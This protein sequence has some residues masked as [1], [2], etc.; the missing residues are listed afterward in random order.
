MQSRI[1]AGAR[2]TVCIKHH[3]ICVQ[4][5]KKSS[6][7]KIVTAFLRCEFVVDR[8]EF[9]PVT[10]RLKGT[11]K[12]NFLLIILQRLSRRVI[13]VNKGQ[14]SVVAVLHGTIVHARLDG[15]LI[16]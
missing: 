8:A 5:A 16:M 1:F 10:N 7:E 6:N 11:A 9:K 14:S 2:P 13:N 3:A 12:E 15:C 4:N